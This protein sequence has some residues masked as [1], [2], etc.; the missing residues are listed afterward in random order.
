MKQV[1]LYHFLGLLIMF[2]STAIS[3]ALMA[4]IL[5]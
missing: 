2:A 1:N 3:M 5:F 4:I